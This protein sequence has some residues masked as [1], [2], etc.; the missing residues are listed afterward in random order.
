LPDLWLATNQQGRRGGCVS[1]RWQG[2]SPRRGGREP[3][4]IGATIGR[5]KA[6]LFPLRVVAGAKPACFRNTQPE[7]VSGNGK[8]AKDGN[9]G[10][11]RKRATV[12]FD[13]P[14]YF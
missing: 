11:T 3:E 10:S 8:G 12:E 4:G 9:V 6:R 14:I 1:P 2:A 7:A 13:S 5:G